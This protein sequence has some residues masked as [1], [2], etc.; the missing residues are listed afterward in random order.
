MLARCPN[1]KSITNYKCTLWG[2]NL[3]ASTATNQGGYREQF[4][5]VVV[6]SN[7]YDKTN[8]TTPGSNVPGL[9]NGADC[10]GKAIDMPSSSVGGKFFPG[11]FNVQ[12]CNEYAVQQNT[13]NRQAGLPTVMKMLNAYYIHKNGVPH[14][15]Y[16]GLF[17]TDLP[18]SFATYTGAQSQGDHFTVQQSWKF[19]LNL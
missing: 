2:S 1:P 12:V 19:V 5:V 8:V 17:S 10:G 15:T 9:S 4:Q 18:S 3:D 11:P 16:C 6:G 14:G 13:V 7:G